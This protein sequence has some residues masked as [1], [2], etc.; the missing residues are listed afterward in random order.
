MHNYILPTKAGL[1][2]EKEKSEI[3]LAGGCK[4]GPNERWDRL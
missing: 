1:F 3:I 4:V 2:Y